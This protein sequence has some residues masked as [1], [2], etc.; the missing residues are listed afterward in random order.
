ME[1]KLWSQANGWPTVDL[2]GQHT[3]PNLLGLLTTD[4]GEYIQVTT[5]GNQ[6]LTPEVA[7]IVTG[8]VTGSLAYG[9]F[10]SGKLPTY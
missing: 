3:R 9:S 2:D 6:T 10:Q 4:D 7:D 8:K 1:R 5:T